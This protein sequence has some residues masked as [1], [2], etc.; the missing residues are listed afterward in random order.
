MRGMCAAGC[1]VSARHASAALCSGLLGGNPRARTSWDLRRAFLSGE[2]GVGSPCAPVRNTRLEARVR[3]FPPRSRMGCP[4]RVQRRERSA[5]HRRLPVSSHGLRTLSPAALS[6]VRFSG[7]Q[8]LRAGTHATH[9][10]A[11]EWQSGATG[12]ARR[13]GR[14]RRA[15]HARAAAQVAQPG[16]ALGL[17]AR[18]QQPALPA[19]RHRER[20]QAAIAPGARRLRNKPR[21]VL[22]L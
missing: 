15:R 17:R 11:A 9:E 3:D 20:V 16:L 18:S 21:T 1:A 8:A 5:R 6:V 4:C 14:G 10:H 19:R 2:G 7:C 12:G 13:T 22:H